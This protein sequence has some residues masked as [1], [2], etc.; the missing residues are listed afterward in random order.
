MTDTRARILDGAGDA[1]VRFGLAKTTVE[2]I[3]SAAGVG[4]A[5]VY[6]W[7]EGGR[8]EVFDALVARELGKVAD[9][10]I[11]RIGSG[12]DLA[13]GLHEVLRWGGPAIRGHTLLQAALD[14]GPEELA[15]RLARLEHGFEDLVAPMVA[16]RLAAS[17]ASPSPEDDAA[18]LVAMMMSVVANPGSWDLEDDDEVGRLVDTLMRSATGAPGSAR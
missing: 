12:D 9:E 14:T 18:Y 4:R 15:V 2:D 5:T 11:V 6:R 3:A 8:S 1:L 16:E 7:F 10:I 17:A 13:A